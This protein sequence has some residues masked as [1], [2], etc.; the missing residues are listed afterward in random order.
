VK[1]TAERGFLLA[2]QVL[3]GIYKK[4]Q[5]VKKTDMRLGVSFFLFKF[6]PENQA[7]IH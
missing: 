6:K 2:L 3:L 1:K 4:K 5:K 7:Y